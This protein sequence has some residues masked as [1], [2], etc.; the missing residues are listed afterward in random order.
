MIVE[1]DVRQPDL[2]QQQQEVRV[3]I[4]AKELPTRE[5]LDQSLPRLRTLLND[6]GMELK[7]LQV[8]DYDSRQGGSAE[9][10]QQQS[11][12][13]RLQTTEPETHDLQTDGL[14]SAGSRVTRS[15]YLI[16]AFV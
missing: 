5:L 3:N 6:S 4:Y 8:A 10:R 12:A 1:I 16:E 11:V 14:N 9:Q 13:G 7:D 15:D 2:A